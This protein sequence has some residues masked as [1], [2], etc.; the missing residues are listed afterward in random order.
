MSKNQLKN[1]LEN[2]KPSKKT[3]ILINGKIFWLTQKELEL[4]KN[5]QSK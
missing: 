4:A 5:L 2:I 3:Q 1:S